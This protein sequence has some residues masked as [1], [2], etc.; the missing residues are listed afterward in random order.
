MPKKWLAAERVA[1][2]ELERAVDFNAL[3][4]L[5]D[6]EDC[7][8]TPLPTACRARRPVRQRLM[9]RIRPPPELA[10]IAL[11]EELQLGA[12][13]EYE[14]SEQEL[15]FS[16]TYAIKKLS[17]VLEGEIA[18]L[19]HRRTSELCRHRTG[20]AVL[21]T[22]VDSDISTLKRW[23][24][25]R[26]W[27]VAT[28]PAPDRPRMHTMTTSRRPTTQI[29]RVDARLSRSLRRRRSAP[30]PNN[31]VR[32]RLALP[33]QVVRGLYHVAPIA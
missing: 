19:K 3:A 9:Y 24:D 6:T 20:R 13:V 33:W 2:L 21:N 4:E 23:V 26:R 30:G 32:H 8:G 14:V 29:P 28:T 18:A 11:E 10:E 5:E 15:S 1:E 17:K 31:R 16:K 22:T 27:R 25:A 7:D 12:Y